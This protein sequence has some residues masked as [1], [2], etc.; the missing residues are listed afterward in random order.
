V[1]RC[2]AIESPEE[3]KAAVEQTKIV[4]LLAGLD[5]ASSTAVAEEVELPESTVR[6]HLNTLLERGHV[7]REGQGK[8]GDPFR[9]RAADTGDVE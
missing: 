5:G 8:R 3:V 9:W 6:R 1:D 7:V 2:V 4:E